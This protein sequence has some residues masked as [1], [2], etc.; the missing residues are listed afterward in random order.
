M[1]LNCDAPV[2]NAGSTAA[3]GGLLRDDGGNFIFTFPVK[4]RTVSVLEA[5]LWG[6]LHGLKLAW[7]RGF[8]HIHVYSDSQGAVN[9]L[10]DGCS[11][12]HVCYP[13]VTAIHEVH[14]DG[15]VVK[16]SHV[17]REANEVADAL[18]KEYLSSNGDV[19]IFEFPLILFL[20]S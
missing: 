6:I 19:G 8:R 15:G 7:S 1:A 12:T 16:W 13:L 18:A 2:I 17:L 10:S 9:L 11:R 3:C 4:L 14:G 5:E 20:M